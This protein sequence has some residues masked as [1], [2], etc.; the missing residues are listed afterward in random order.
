MY[1]EAAI[2][3]ALVR[4]WDSNGRNEFTR[5]LV[6]LT[7]GWD[8]SAARRPQGRHHAPPPAL[9]APDLTPTAVYR[10]SPTSVHLVNP[11]VG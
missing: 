4:E 1:A 7:A 2:F 6:K 5:W 3:D 10:V 8:A 11:R 9:R